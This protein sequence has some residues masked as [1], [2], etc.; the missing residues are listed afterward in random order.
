MEVV[1]LAWEADGLLKLGH[2]T[3]VSAEVEGA[4]VVPALQRALGAGFKH[5]T[6][7]SVRANVGQAVRVF[8]LDQH[9][10]LARQ[11]FQM[12]DWKDRVCFQFSEMGSKLPAFEDAF[13]AL[14]FDRV[15][16]EPGRKGLGL[17]N[18]GVNHLARHDSDTSHAVLRVGTVRFQAPFDSA[19]GERVVHTEPSNQGRQPCAQHR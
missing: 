6:H 8:A 19:N 10:R 13:E 14:V 16:V 11:G 9:D 5:Q 7:A 15:G 12:V 1:G 18:V 2:V 17:S 4:P 3:Q